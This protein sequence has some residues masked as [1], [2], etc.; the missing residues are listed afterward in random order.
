M[1]AHDAAVAA[2]AAAA[3]AAKSAD[4]VAFAE[5]EVEAAH[6]MYATPH[7][8]EPGSGHEGERAQYLRREV[9][10]VTEETTVTT[11]GTTSITMTGATV[12]VMSPRSS[13]TSDSTPEVHKDADLGS[14]PIT[15]KTATGMMETAVKLD[16][17]WASS[18]DILHKDWAAECGQM[19]GTSAD[20]STRSRPTPESVKDVVSSLTEDCEDGAVAAAMAV[21]AS[22]KEGGFL[23]GSVMQ[24]GAAGKGKVTIPA[25]FKADATPGSRTTTRAPLLSRSHAKNP[26]D[27]GDLRVVPPFVAAM[28]RK[29]EED[30]YQRLTDLCQEAKEQVAE[31]EEVI[32]KIRGEL[33]YLQGRSERQ[34]AEKESYV[35]R[36]QQ[37]KETL[38]RRILEA[39][40]R[41]RELQHHT[42][43]ETRLC[44]KL[45]KVA[46]EAVADMLDEAKQLRQQVEDESVASNGLTEQLKLATADQAELQR[47]LQEEKMVTFK[48]ARDVLVKFTQGKKEQFER[49]AAEAL[50]GEHA[51]SE[52][53]WTPHASCEDLQLELLRRRTSW[54][55]EHNAGCEEL[56]R[57]RDFCAAQVAAVDQYRKNLALE[58]AGRAHREAEMASV[59]QRSPEDTMRPPEHMRQQA[60][61]MATTAAYEGKLQVPGPDLVA[62]VHEADG[63]HRALRALA[64][65]SQTHS[66]GKTPTLPPPGHERELHEMRIDL[67]SHEENAKAI[68]E[69]KTRFNTFQA[70]FTKRVEEAQKTL[71]DTEE[72]SAVKQYKRTADLNRARTNLNQCR[73]VIQQLRE[74]LEAGHGC[75]GKRKRASGKVS[76]A[77]SPG[78]V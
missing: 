1:A 72:G 20:A 77:G 21:P 45:R 9:T 17:M 19:E 13:R 38:R 14:A 29:D 42:E 55:E 47:Q 58:S 11:M 76:R 3:A 56:N 28:L 24:T 22:L 35:A 66:A 5:A 44:Q 64:K 43:E 48:E 65:R 39:A 70:E 15:P 68:T 36:L 27:A 69:G 4:L 40:E 73:D 26:Q 18:P 60:E 62:L 61:I 50:S 41:R 53:P 33:M 6:E 54:L 57:L 74:E 7:G 32:S 30:E 23:H 49:E 34:R 71:K 52:A 75:C 12:Y 78:A 46:A 2:E 8:A 63:I 67:Q 10:T 16:G 51:D 25:C 31:Q 59:A 37:A